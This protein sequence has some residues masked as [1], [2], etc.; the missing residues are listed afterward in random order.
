MDDGDWVNR[1]YGRLDLLKG[2]IRAS[3]R[4]KCH[5]PPSPPLPPLWRAC[6]YVR[7]VVMY[8]VGTVGTK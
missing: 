4:S 1:K 5:A 2:R 7:C 8:C 6:V 3:V